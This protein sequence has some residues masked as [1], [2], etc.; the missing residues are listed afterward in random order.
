MKTINPKKH[1]QPDSGK[2][3]G[4]E[5]SEVL[6]RIM[7]K[8]LIAQEKARRQALMQAC[9]IADDPPEC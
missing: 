3:L 7:A 4:M 5:L 1:S 8:H 9:G 2:T 6:G